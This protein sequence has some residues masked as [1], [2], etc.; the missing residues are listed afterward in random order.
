VTSLLKKWKAILCIILVGL[1]VGSAA[2][3][4]ITLLGNRFYGARTEFFVSS[5]ATNNYILSMLKSDSYAEALLMDENGLPAEYAG[6][7]L[8]NEAKAAREKVAEIKKQIKEAEESLEPMEFDISKLSKAYSESQTAYNEALALLEMYKKADGQALAAAGADAIANHYAVLKVYEQELNTRK[9]NKETARAAY[10][11]ALEQKQTVEQ[12]VLTLT[13]ELEEATKA[14]NEI[15]ATVHRQFMAV[16]ENSEKIEKIK[17]YVSVGFVDETSA[18]TDKSASNAVIYV[19]IAVPSDP[20]AAKFLL[21][22]VSDKTLK[23]IESNIDDEKASLKYLT[24]FASADKIEVYEPVKTVV[25]YAAILAVGAAAVYCFCFVV[26]V[27]VKPPKKTEEKLP[28]T[29][30]E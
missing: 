5:T 24:S 12:S 3:L 9:A 18:D 20:E 10:N 19:D 28:E 30:E 7:D 14:Q 13:R 29:V 11:S 4:T 26:A 6:T 23:F 25:Q 8:Y 17:K 21:D 16:P 27:M 15:L 1:L 2:G 22:N